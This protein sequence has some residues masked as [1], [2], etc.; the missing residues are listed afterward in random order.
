LQNTT[1]EKLDDILAHYGLG[2]NRLSILQ[3]LRLIKQ[4]LGLPV[5]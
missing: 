1:E 3:K 2:G 4:F 5:V